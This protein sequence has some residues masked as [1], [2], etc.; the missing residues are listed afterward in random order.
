MEPVIS[1][2]KSLSRFTFSSS[3]AAK[4]R[5]LPIVAR[6]MVTDD[7]QQHELNPIMLDYTDRTYTDDRKHINLLNITNLFKYSYNKLF[8]IK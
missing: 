7:Q 1:S 2:T 3:S 5:K 4:V 6:Q 8:T